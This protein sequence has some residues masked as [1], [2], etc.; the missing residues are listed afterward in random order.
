M[1]TRRHF[2]SFLSAATFA[3]P[4]M[5]VPSNLSQ[6][7]IKGAFQIPRRSLSFYNIHTGE[8]L[9]RCV[10]WV[11]GEYQPEPLAAIHTLFRDHRTHEEH[12]IDPKLLDMLAALSHKLDAGNRPFHLVSGYRSS[13]SNTMLHEASTGVARNSQHLYG[14]AADI[15]MEGRSLKQI[16]QAAKSLKAGGVGRYSRF[17]HV[18][19]G[20]VR[21]WGAV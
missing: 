15:F 20:R 7:L 9:S 18:D 5:L 14:R 3:A 2:L 21:Y 10:Y 6:K 17:V 11:E 13:T 12:T 4:I 1:I 8:S 19:T 16:Q